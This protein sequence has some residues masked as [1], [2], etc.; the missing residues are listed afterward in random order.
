ME[1]SAIHPIAQ[2]LLRLEPDELPVLRVTRDAM[3]H[4]AGRL[5]DVDASRLADMVL[6]DPL[7]CLRTLQH[8][9]A[10]IGRR[11]ANP[12]Q[13]VTAALVLT[14]IEPFFRN[15]SQLTALEDRLADQPK[16]LAGALETIKR[17]HCAARIAAAFAVYRQDD[18]AELLHQAALLHDFA[19]LL[20]WWEAPGVALDIRRR[21][22]ED[23]RLRSADAQRALLGCDLTWI[24][25]ELLEHWGLA[26]VVREAA[27]ALDEDGP[28]AQTVRYAVRIAR[29]LDKG[30][31]HPAIADDLREAGRLLNLGPDGVASLVRGVL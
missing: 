24:S 9:S 31:H 1:P 16:A 30:W 7:M 21:Q 2:R 15:F 4:W 22:R 14:G 23:E 6:R 13:T 26:A 3:A 8:V 18:D 27:R 28:A 5:D 29:H 20:L 17:A 12:V 19:G 11:L 10:S 25:R